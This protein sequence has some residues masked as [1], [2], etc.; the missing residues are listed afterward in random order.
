RIYQAFRDL[1][2]AADP[3]NLLNPG[4]IVNLGPGSAVPPMGAS[5][6]Y[7]PDYSTAAVRQSWVSVLDFS[8]QAGLDGAVEQCNGAGVCRKADGVMCPSFQATQEEM[9]ST[10][11][12]ANL[13]RALLSG[14]FPA[15]D[16][17]E[18][19]VYE[20]LD[21]CLACKGC[22]AECPSAVDMAKL[23]YEF[24]QRWADRHGRRVR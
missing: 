9:H 19:S 17:A 10:R 20:A 3:H 14:R 4:K 2:A 22:K 7:E 15:Q 24:E 13:L 11:G 21:L 18:K 5:L 16:L 1:K 8:A 12:R 23:K 6:R